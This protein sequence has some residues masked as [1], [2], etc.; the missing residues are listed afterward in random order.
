MRKDDGLHE[1]QPQPQQQHQHQQQQQPQQQQ[2]RKSP[3]S[4]NKETSDPL[5]NLSGTTISRVSTFPTTGSRVW[6]GIDWAR[7]IVRETTTAPRVLADVPISPRRRPSQSKQVSISPPPEV[8]PM[9]PPK[10]SSS[11]I[12]V[13]HGNTPARSRTQD[14]K[15]NYHQQ[16]QQRQRQRSL[17]RRS[18]PGR[19]QT[20]EVDYQ[21]LQQQRGTSLNARARSI[22]RQ[23]EPSNATRLPGK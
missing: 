2:Q 4:N 11:S 16:Q 3:E 18:G 10:A 23:S 1:Q 8:V 6:T 9:L 15:K 13:G 12:S 17:E 22:E 5:P 19:R 20:A 21:P 14:E 7:E